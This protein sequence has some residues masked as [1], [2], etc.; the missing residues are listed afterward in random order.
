MLTRHLCQRPSASADPCLY[1]CTTAVRPQHEPRGR[2][3]AGADG[4]PVRRRICGAC[5]QEPG[6]PARPALSHQPVQFGGGP[7]LCRARAAAPVDGCNEEH[8]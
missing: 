8:R 4:Q 3:F 6:V 2:G 1:P 7:L 5:H